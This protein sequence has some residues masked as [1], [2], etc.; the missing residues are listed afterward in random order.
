MHI[1]LPHFMIFIY[2]LCHIKFLQFSRLH[3]RWRVQRV[4]VSQIQVMCAVFYEHGNEAVGKVL[5]N[6]A[7]WPWIKF[8]VAEKKRD[9]V[10]QK[11]VSITKQVIPFF[12]FSNSETQP[13]PWVANF[14]EVFGSRRRLI[15]LG[16]SN[17]NNNQ[18]V[19]CDSTIEQCI[20]SK[21]ITRL[22]FLAY[23][24]NCDPE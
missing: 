12:F 22:D 9:A 1:L 16:S 13:P 23:H 5:G 8:A 15:G 17:R 11:L 21:T 20:V 3:D 4:F 10:M 2:P 6:S 18:R 7:S 19:Q 14:S 24:A